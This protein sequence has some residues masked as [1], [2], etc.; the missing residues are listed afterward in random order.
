METG[1]ID[2]LLQGV[3]IAVLEILGGRLKSY[4]ASDATR[5]VGDGRCA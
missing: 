3:A 2:G 5:D 4:Q 1:H